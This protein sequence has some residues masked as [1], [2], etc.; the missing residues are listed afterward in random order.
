[1]PDDRFYSLISGTFQAREIGKHDSSKQTKN[2]SADQEPRE[3]PR[4]SELTFTQ[5]K[6]S[7]QL[8][9][10]KK[11]LQTTPRK[12]EMNKIGPKKQ[13]IVT[14]KG[15]QGVERSNDQSLA[16]TRE[17]KHEVIGYLGDPTARTCRRRFR[18]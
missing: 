6:P 16:R 3:K 12:K 17:K 10:K 8:F 1:M 7:K 18:G 13:P 4:V 2:P 5:P 9:A 15:E 14:L 11:P